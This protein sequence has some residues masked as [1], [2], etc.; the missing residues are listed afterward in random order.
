MIQT[1]RSQVTHNVVLQAIQ[2]HLLT[3]ATGMKQLLALAT[4]ILKN[5]K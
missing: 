4:E 5:I 2:R 3:L 1:Y